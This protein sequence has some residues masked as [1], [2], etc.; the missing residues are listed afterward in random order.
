MK[1]TVFMALILISSTSFAYTLIGEG[2][3]SEPQILHSENGGV[4]DFQVVEKPVSTEQI[5]EFQDKKKY[6][7]NQSINR[8]TFSKNIKL[9]HLH[10]PTL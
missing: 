7:L 3:V 2:N 5:T 4:K 8:S 9:S 6:P 10:C 1:K